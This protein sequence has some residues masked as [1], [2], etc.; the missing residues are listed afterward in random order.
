MRLAG[1]RHV[2]FV[3]MT[4]LLAE[5]TPESR[6]RVV[7]LL[8][9]VSIIV[10][11]FGHW[12]MAALTIDH[13][14]HAGNILSL[15]AWTHPFTWL[16]QVM[17]VFFL[18][19]GYA[20]ARSWRSARGRNTGYG[21]W[22]RG[23]TRRLVLPVLPVLVCWLAVGWL[24]LFLGAGWRT[25]RLAS[26]VALMP[27]WF[28]AAYIAVTTTTP[29]ALWL[30]RRWG[31]GSVAAGLGCAAVVDVTSLVSGS[32]LAGF[33]NYLLVWG[34]VHQLGF[35]W[36]DGALAAF[37]KR[38]LLCLTGLLGTLTLVLLGP[39]PVSMVGVDTSTVTNTYPPRVT[40]LLLGM[41]QAGLVLMFEDPAARAMRRLRAWIVVVAL[42]GRIM[43]LYL[44]HITA[45]VLVIALS[46]TLG[47]AGLT[48][49]PLTSLW[50]A[51]R[52]V[53]YLVL[54]TVTVAL[55]A[56]LGRFETPAADTRPA[57]P[58]WRPVLAAA[59]VCAGLGALA[60]LGLASAHGLNWALLV[61]PIVSV[62][63]GGVAKP[64][65]S[66]FAAAR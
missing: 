54:G 18:V 33:V 36:L 62:Y 45:M 4:R 40:L 3:A 10:V 27:T 53:W 46:L 66:G 35:A 13:G 55:V 31:W 47:G 38:L 34:T 1:D 50:W 37:W 41:F 20:N 17:P 15:A 56:L 59:G 52:P 58:W 61:L 29:A 19:G 24:A 39:Y 48:V 44:W 65:W 63:L 16:F 8:R 25:L 11:V 28:L 14:L 30:W 12:T 49:A 2:G 22:L 7:D 43:T 9:A 21:S 42:N 51:T 5:A 23:R 32:T 64:P 57:P 60:V 26:T 6:N